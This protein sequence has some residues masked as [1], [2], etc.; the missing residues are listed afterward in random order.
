[1]HTITVYLNDDQYELQSDTVVGSL[2][3]ARCDESGLPYIGALV[4]NDASSLSYPLT[5]NCKVEFITI[6]NPHGWRIYRNSLC[7]LLAK[8]VNDLFPDAVFS[9]EHSFGLGLYCTFRKTGDHDNGDTGTAL[10]E[11]STYMRAL[12]DR[13]IPIE[14]YKISYEDAVNNFQSAG[15]SHKLNLLRY[16]NPPRI[17]TYCCDGFS[18]LAHGPL[19][20]ATGTLNRFELLPYKSGF[21]LHLPDRSNPDTIS[22]FEDQPHLFEVFRE[23]K[24]WG[25]TQNVHTVGRLNEIVFNS[26]IDN[27]IAACEAL[28]E[29]KISRIAEAVAEHKSDIKLIMIAGPSSAGKTTF[30]KRLSTH[31]IVNGLQ[32]LTIS[33]DNYFVGA[34][35]NPINEDG[36]PDYEHIEAVD[37]EL[38]NDH[39][40]QLISGEEVKLPFFNF[41]TKKREY[42]GNC[43]KVHDGQILIIEGIH[44]LNPRLSSS[45]P[46][47]NKSRIY[48][49]ALTQINLDTNNRISTTDNRLMRRMIRDYTFR[50]HSPLET[51]QLWPNVRRGEKKWIFP[52]QREADITFNSAL[53]YELA[54]LKPMVEPLLMQ[55][56]PRH[57]EYAEARRLSEF[58]CNFLGTSDKSI[59]M[60]SILREYIGGSCL[61][62]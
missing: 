38:L 23:H 48:I 14:R 46:G 43:M 26:E 17:V 53:D 29:K 35:R 4:N 37:L 42:P 11:I 18:D 58:L 50:G 52:F 2:L 47:E 33:V 20:P 15:Q 21:V 12:V 7:F 57:K 55:I 8:A 62:Y 25:R 28:H 40:E 16:R 60:D 6:A 56:K 41:K 24:E 5:V 13:N 10:T 51:L 30:A 22:V 9:V 61:K 54:V 32:P 49:S 39:L 59:P 34:D 1:M 27:F 45:V 44:C 19:V 31:L 3:E 36:N